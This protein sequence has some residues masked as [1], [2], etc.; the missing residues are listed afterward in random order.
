M[1]KIVNT[2]PL[3][4]ALT[5]AAVLAT[6]L[7]SVFPWL[8]GL[9]VVWPLVHGGTGHLVAN[10]TLFLLLSPTLE[11]RHGTMR[12]GVVYLTVAVVLGVSYGFL[13]GGRLIGGSGHVF[14]AIGLA[15]FAGARE[16]EVPLHLILLVVIYGVG[17]VMAA[18]R[19]DT[20]S[21]FAH[22]GG[23]AIGVMAGSL[24]AR[25]KQSRNR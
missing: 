6:I 16:R 23:L 4:T 5:L 7:A 22:L 11:E 24:L 19:A 20:V 8:P 9:G 10:L 15:G 14:A 2:A 12:L 17:E 21:Q 1:P 3:T 13:F 18:L 25:E